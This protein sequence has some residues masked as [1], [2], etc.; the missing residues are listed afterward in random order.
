MYI[1]YEAICEIKAL[2]TNIAYGS[3]NFLLLFNS[4]NDLN[5]FLDSI[6]WSP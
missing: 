4:Y 2:N 5:S 1:Q 3:H 6:L